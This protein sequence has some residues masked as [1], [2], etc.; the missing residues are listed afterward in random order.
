[1]TRDSY[2]EIYNDDPT[3]WPKII[4]QYEFDWAT[5]DI[6]FVAEYYKLEEKAETIR[7]FQ[8]IDGTEERYTATDFENDETLEETLMAIGTRE[9]RQKRVKRMHG[10]SQACQGCAAPQEYAAKQAGRDKRTVK[11]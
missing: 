2:K 6:V 4:H 3:D 9:V 8:A 5:P 11:H 10:R 7:I 1:M